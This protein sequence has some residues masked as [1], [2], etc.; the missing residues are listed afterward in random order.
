[1]IKIASIE[2]FVHQGVAIAL[3]L[4]EDDETKINENSGKNA[5]FLLFL[6]KTN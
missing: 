1:L 4:P 2:G 6:S 3:T 5:F